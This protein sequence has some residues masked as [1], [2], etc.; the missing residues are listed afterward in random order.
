MFSKLYSYE[1]FYLNI[2][3]FCYL[4]LCR[5]MLPLWPASLGPAE[6]LAVIPPVASLGPWLRC[7]PLVTC[8]V[9]GSAPGRQSPLTRTAVRLGPGG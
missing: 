3:E 2:A 8:H 1:M 7:G 9:R 5:C 6:P 4:R